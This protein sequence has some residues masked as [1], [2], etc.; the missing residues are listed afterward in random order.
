[1][2]LAKPFV[3]Y[4]EGWTHAVHEDDAALPMSSPGA[5]HATRLCDNLLHDYPPPFVGPHRQT[6]MCLRR[7]IFR[8]LFL[9]YY[10]IVLLGAPIPMANG[11]T[12]DQT[13]E[14]QQVFPCAGGTCGCSFEHCWSNCCCHTLSERLDWARKNNV[15]PPKSAID[16]AISAGLDV[17]CWIDWDQRHGTRQSACHG[18]NHAGKCCKPDVPTIAPNSESGAGNVRETKGVVIIE[19]MACR[20]ISFA[21]STI[22]AAPPPAPIVI[23]PQQVVAHLDVAQTHIDLPSSPQPP[24]PPPRSA[25]APHCQ[26]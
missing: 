17:S 15:R 19:A 22:V 2:I 11:D 25:L 21:W 14:T 16:Q 8:T 13:V 20:G 5:C 6:D 12:A 18:A 26:A 10:C 9:Q 7:R 24:T 4:K 1:M 3:L 23:S